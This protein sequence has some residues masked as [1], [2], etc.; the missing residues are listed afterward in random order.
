MQQAPQKQR[1]LKSHRLNEDAQRR[2]G[3]FQ[4]EQ[5]LQSI[6]TD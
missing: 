2:V 1:S 6:A 5:R 3:N 4:P